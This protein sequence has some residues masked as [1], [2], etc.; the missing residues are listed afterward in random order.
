MQSQEPKRVH[1]Q[2]AHE[3]L[4][5]NRWAD[6]DTTFAGMLQNLVDSTAAANEARSM[7][8]DHGK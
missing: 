6:R 4:Q 7:G 5:P 3:A 2:I 1:L 8:E